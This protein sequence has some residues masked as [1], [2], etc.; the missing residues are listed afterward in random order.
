[1][2]LAEMIRRALATDDV[3]L[4]ERVTFALRFGAIKFKGVP[5]LYSYSNVLETVARVT[6]RDV[7]DVGIE[8]EQLLARE[9]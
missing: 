3:E 1:M 4:A 5:V 2:S 9:F 7:G 8:W 6:G